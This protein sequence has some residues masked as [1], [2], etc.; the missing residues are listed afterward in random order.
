MVISIYEDKIKKF[1]RAES[2]LLEQVNELTES[3]KI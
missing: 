2:L 1:K 3:N